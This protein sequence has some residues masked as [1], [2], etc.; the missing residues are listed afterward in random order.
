MKT[1]AT[2]W[3]MR[4][5]AL[6]L[7]RAWSGGGPPA[8]LEEHLAEL[9][10][11]MPA[12][13]FWLFGKTQSGKTSVIKYLTGA[14]AAE[15]GTGFR[16]CTR[17]SRQY[18][19]PTADAPLLTFLDTRGIDEPGYDPAEDLA[20]FDHQAHVVLVTVKVTDHALQNVLGPL[21]TV[22]KVR[23]GRPIVLALT[24]LHE[25]YPQQQHPAPYPFHNFTPGA[26]PPAGIPESLSRL[27]AEQAKRFE[28]LVDAIV[29]VDLTRPEEGYDEPN[30]GG[31]A[32]KDVLVGQLPHAY[33]QTLVR[34]DDATHALQDLH[35]RH[36]API[37]LGYSTLA[38]T[39]GACPIP[40][41]DLL[42]LPGIQGRMVADLARLY[43]QPLTGPRFL[44]VATSLGLGV[45]ARQAVR[46]VVKF[47]PFVG[48]VAGAALAGASTY[49]LGRAF[50]Y[51]YRAVHEGHVPNPQDLKRFY[52]EQLKAAE[53]NWSAGQPQQ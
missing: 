16:P 35:L 4:E 9:R 42:V 21:Q 38:A 41:L 29:P 24:C 28:G 32:L 26:A 18:H 5:A 13:V 7:R 47:I 49:A 33:R 46:E 36:A 15:I 22:R 25:A 14:D 11:Q 1:A 12:P 52:D 19:F 31:H 3:S 37:I 43:G 27:L 20:T 23:R 6:A 45:A 44:E 51:Y 2:A 48:T 17:T 30:Y 39:A 8:E 53:K 40:F 34:L 50:C 10:R